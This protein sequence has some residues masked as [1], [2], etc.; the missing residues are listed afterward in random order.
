MEFGLHSRLK[1]IWDLALSDFES[2]YVISM[3]WFSYIQVCDVF[4]VN[5]IFVISLIGRMGH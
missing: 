3:F 2:F 4:L 1:L 5:G